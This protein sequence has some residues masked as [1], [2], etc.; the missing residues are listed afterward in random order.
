MIKYFYLVDFTYLTDEGLESSFDLGVFSTK[1]NAEEKIKKSVNLNGFKDYTINNFKIIKFGVNFDDDVKDKSNVILYCV[2]HEYEDES[3]KFIYYWNIFDYL[4]T[5]EKANSK[6]EYLK[7]H[8]RIGRKY[9]DN[10]EIVEV[11]IDKFNSWSEGFV[12]IND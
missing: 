3:N 7:K 1:K 11:P 6:V 4:S 12:E 8:S 5:M 9:P 10:F 2:T